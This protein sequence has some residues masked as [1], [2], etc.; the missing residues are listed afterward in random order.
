MTGDE[1]GNP[2]GIRDRHRDESDVQRR[3]VD[4]HVEVL[5]QRVQPLAVRGCLRQVGRE[6]VVVHDHQ[7]DEEH[8]DGRDHRDD[9]GNQ[10]AMPLAVGVDGD[11]PE[12]PE[13][14][15][16]EHDR[17]VE[18]AP[19]RG[20]LVG[21]RLRGVRVA[22]HVLDRVVVGDEGVDHHRRRDRH[23]R[24]DQIERADAAF[25]QAPRSPPGAGH[26]CGDRVG[27]RQRSS[28]AG[29]RC[30][31]SAMTRC[32][33]RLALPASYF[34]GHFA[35]TPFASTA[36]PSDFRWP[37]STTSDPSLNVSGTMPV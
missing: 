6:R 2:E 5:E 25:D 21:Q 27:G 16:P 24:G 30:R 10:L 28:R 35:I 23:Q 26:R 20:D 37:F 14:E 1:R 34:D 33:G 32:R 15:H 3:R 11:R 7:E 17:A 4:R 29:G 8:L 36:K 22:L 12:D 18:P 19:V 31:D 9:V 13:Q